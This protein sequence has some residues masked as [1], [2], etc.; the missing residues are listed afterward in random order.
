MPIALAVIGLA[1][2]ISGARGEAGNLGTQV[3]SDLKGGYLDWLAAVA[4]VGFVGYVPGLQSL[5]RMMLGLI[6]LVMV[7][8]NGGIWTNLQKAAQTNPQQD[9][10]VNYDY[11]SSSGS[12]SSSGGGIGGAIGTVTGLAS[13]FGG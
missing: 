11:T 1:L 8:K 2:I 4:L 12:S 13:L 10:T 7:I 6:I 3:G 5:S 9:G